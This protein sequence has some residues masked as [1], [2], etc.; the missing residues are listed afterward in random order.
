MRTINAQLTLPDTV[1]LNASLQ[2]GYDPV[3]EYYKHLCC[4]L[5]ATACSLYVH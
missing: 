1:T 5:V 4:V 3:N 2:L